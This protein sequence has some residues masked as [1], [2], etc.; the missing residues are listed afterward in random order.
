[1]DSNKTFAQIVSEEG[2]TFPREEARTVVKPSESKH[3]SGGLALAKAAR[4]S[5]RDE[6][7]LMAIMR[8]GK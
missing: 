8:G 1:M 3:H 7:I 6:N 5:E 4:I 2:I